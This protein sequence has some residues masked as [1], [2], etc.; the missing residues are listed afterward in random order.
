MT[1]DLES[2]LGHR[3]DEQ[4]ARE[5]VAGCSRAFTELVER[6]EGRLLRF[7]RRWASSEHDAEDITQD[8]FVEAW[9]CLHRYDDRWRFSTW[10]YT[11]AS[12]RAASHFR[13]RKDS[14]SAMVES[15]EDSASLAPE[16]AMEAGENRSR[17]WQLAERLLSDEQRTALLLRYSEGMSAS[18][19]G[20]V[21]GK[22]PVAVRVML[23]RARERLAAELV[24][25]DEKDLDEGTRLQRPDQTVEP[26][27]FDGSERRI[28]K[29]TTKRSKGRSAKTLVG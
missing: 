11:I 20:Q 22:Q 16:H 7:V 17:M 8:A 9:R 14:T 28:D 26:L 4:L 1:L 24:P 29:L 3:T 23:F 27:P 19:I 13:R 2:A 12:R 21:L 15:H 10:L 6:Y 5:S 18:E 25:A